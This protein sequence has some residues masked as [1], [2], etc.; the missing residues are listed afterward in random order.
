MWESWKMMCHLKYVWQTI[1]GQSPPPTIPQICS[2]T[3]QLFFPQ[4]GI[5]TL[6]CMVGWSNEDDVGMDMLSHCCRSHWGRIYHVRYAWQTIGAIR[7][8]LPHLWNMISNQPGFHNQVGIYNLSWMVEWSK[9]EDA[10]WYSHCCRI[11]GGFMD[12]IHW[13]CL[14]KHMVPAIAS[15]NTSDISSNQPGFH[16]KFGYPPS[17]GRWSGPMRRI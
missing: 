3:N 15:N 13:S 10:G 6:S 17:P 14:A 1:Q 8:L 16:T 9:E 5:H 4:V 12:S 11:L 2:A 7:C